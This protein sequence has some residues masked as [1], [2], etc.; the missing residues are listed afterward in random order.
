MKYSF[1]ILGLILL[2]NTAVK[3]QSTKPANTYPSNLEENQYFESYDAATQTIKGIHFL[4][5][6]D[7]DN[8]LDRT[9]EFTVKLTSI[10]KIKNQFLSKPIPSIMALHTCLGEILTNKI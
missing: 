1:I 8:S 7:G 5:L 9:P 4:V 2:G 3:A 10:N 6:S